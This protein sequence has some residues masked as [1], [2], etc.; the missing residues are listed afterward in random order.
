MRIQMTFAIP[1]PASLPYSLNYYLTSYFYRAIREVN[2]HLSGWLHSEG[3]A[4]RG[5][6][7]KPF[8]FSRPWFDLRT[9]FPTHMEVQGKCRIQVD[10]I[11]VEVVR[12]IYEGVNQL[13]C[14][15]LLGER[16]PLVDLRVKEAISFA[17]RMTYETISPITVPV[18]IDDE[19]HFCHP[20]ESRFYDNLRYSLYN[21]YEIKW[22]EPFPDHEE[23]HIQLVDPGSFQLERAAVL[24][25]YHGKNIKAY[26]LKLAIEAPVKM[27]Q[28]IYEAGLGSYGSQGFGMV[29]VRR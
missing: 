20:L 5:K 17:P 16:F 19:L 10:S 26:Q 18:R 3:I 25:Q 27:Q 15:H 21:W 14:L 29:E 7:Y 23:I 12:S 4:F 22:K 8:L 1:K 6:A 24:I 11:Q 28:V 2:P 9:H 13:G